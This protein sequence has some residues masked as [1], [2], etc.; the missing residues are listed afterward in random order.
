MAGE[1]SSVSSVR[2]WQ[3]MDRG[4]GMLQT[5]S[6]QLGLDL[7]LNWI[8]HWWCR[9]CNGS[10][11]RLLWFLEYSRLPVVVCQ[12]FSGPGLSMEDASTQG[13]RQDKI[14]H[15]IP[16]RE[17]ITKCGIF[18][19]NTARRTNSRYWRVRCIVTASKSGGVDEHSLGVLEVNSICVGTVPRRRDAHIMDQNSLA[20][21]ELEMALRAILNRYACDRHIKTPIK[22][23]CLYNQ[24]KYKNHVTE[25]AGQDSRPHKLQDFGTL[26]GPYRRFDAWHFP[27]QLASY[28]PQISFTGWWLV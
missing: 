7:I 19:F 17:I 14:A 1:F 21:V 3:N 4:L 27:A 2:W 22:P 9:V 20:V 8:D 28:L 5:K 26:S 10:H 11:E 6:C 16:Q 12:T 23:Q 24:Q 13:C 25:T 18:E 15:G